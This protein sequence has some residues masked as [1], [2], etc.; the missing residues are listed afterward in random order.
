MMPGLKLRRVTPLARAPDR[1]FIEQSA[2]HCQNESHQFS[3]RRKIATAARHPRRPRGMT[4]RPDGSLS[5]RAYCNWALLEP[6]VV[7][8]SPA[9]APRL[10][11]RPCNAC[12]HLVSPEGAP[13]VLRP[14]GSGVSGAWPHPR[15]IMA[16]SAPKTDYDPQTGERT[17]PESICAASESRPP[18]T[19]LS[20]SRGPTLSPRRMNLSA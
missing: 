8:S 1:N 12:A 2:M 5:A 4:R 6:L 10:S 11:C 16:W 18:A 17:S 9:K 14:R 3:R 13:A 19:Q 7:R 15:T 20:T